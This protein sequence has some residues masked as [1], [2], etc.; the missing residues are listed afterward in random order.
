MSTR[1]LPWRGSKGAN[2]SVGFDDDLFG[3]EA[4]QAEIAL[5]S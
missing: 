2:I 1:V 4:M 3:A 5:M